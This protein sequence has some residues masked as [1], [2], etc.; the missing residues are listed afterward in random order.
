M[1]YKE[2]NPIL[3]S[4]LRLTIISYLVAN[5]DADFKTL[6]QQ[7]GATPGNLSVQLRKLEQA[8]YIQIIKTFKDNYQHTKIRLTE[9]GL[10][11][12]EEYVEALK[13]YIFVKPKNK[14][15]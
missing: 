4:Q 12:F 3:H 1:S 11:A 8:G 15:Q 2:L 5:G 6:L 10:N 13:Q 9:Q 14:E 7:T